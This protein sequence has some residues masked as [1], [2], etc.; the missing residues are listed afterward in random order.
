[1]RGDPGRLAHSAGT[2]DGDDHAVSPAAGA[3]DRYRCKEVLGMLV[4][5]AIWPRELP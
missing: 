2:F 1:M 4:L 5:A 3:A